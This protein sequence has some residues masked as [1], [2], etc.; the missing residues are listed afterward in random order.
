MSERQQ[1]EFICRNIK[2][3]HY[4]VECCIIRSDLNLKVDEA[5]RK[6]RR[7]QL[8]TKESDLSIE[9]KANK[10]DAR[11]RGGGRFGGRGGRGR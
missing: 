2:D 8:E 10:S 9:V 11:G 1:I 4:S 5:Q 3:S 6:L 7:L